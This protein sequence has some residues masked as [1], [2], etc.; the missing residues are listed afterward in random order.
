MRKRSRRHGFAINEFNVNERLEP[1]KT[2]IVEFVADK[3]GTFSF[4][5]FDI[6]RHWPQWNEGSW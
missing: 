1:G 5:L 2:V 4:L 3:T 6:L